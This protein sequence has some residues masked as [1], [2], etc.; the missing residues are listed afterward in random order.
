ML[1]YC[2]I[3]CVIIFYKYCH[4]EVLN[5]E[6]NFPCKNSLETCL[7][8]VSYIVD[9]SGLNGIPKSKSDIDVVCKGFKIG[10]KCL[11][12]Y[13]RQCL[14]E[15]QKN[16]INDH[17]MGA[18]YTF[19]FLCDDIKFQN[20]YLKY[21]DCYRVINSDWDECTTKFTSL[22]RETMYSNYS[23]EIKVIDLLQSMDF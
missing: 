16:L 6:N 1:K 15:E 12:D 23:E 14:T 7:G 9:N 13:S 2:G 11:D 18:K 3:Y 5:L 21:T 20:D 19:K 4:G 10:M 17:I 22:I 8:H